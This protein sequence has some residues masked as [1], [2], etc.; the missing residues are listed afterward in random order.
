MR[1]KEY[2]III[3]DNCGDYMLGG[4]YI[5]RKGRGSAIC[6]LCL[7]ELYL[8][9]FKTEKPKDKIMVTRK[10]IKEDVRNAIFKR[11]GYRCVLC[12]GMENLTIDHVKPFIKGGETE[13]ENFQTLC[14]K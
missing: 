10:A 5:L 8:D 2:G 9:Y 12:S 1:D 11:D 14:R 7:E 6:Y 3:C 4:G 13:I